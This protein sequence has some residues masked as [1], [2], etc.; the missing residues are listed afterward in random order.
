[1]QFLSGS[2]ILIL[3]I[4]CFQK[5]YDYLYD[6]HLEWTEYFGVGMVNKNK[7]SYG[8]L[9]RIGFLTGMAVM[10]VM[11]AA[12]LAGRTMPEKKD[13]GESFILTDDAWTLDTSGSIPADMKHLGDGF[14]SDSDVLSIYYRLPRMDVAQSLVWRTKDV[15]TRLAVDGEVLYETEVPQSRF[16]SKSPGNIWN[17]CDIMPEYSG[18]V[19]EMQ[20]KYAYDESTVTVDHIYM[21]NEA[22]IVTGLISGKTGALLI[23]IFM[24]LAGLFMLFINFIPRLNTKKGNGIFYLGLNTLFSGIWSLLETNVVQFFVSDARLLQMVGNVVMM[25]SVLPLLL[26]LDCEYHIL[27]N[28]FLQLLSC[29]DIVFLIVCGIGQ[30]TGVTDL[31][32]M[33][34]ISLPFV[35]IFHMVLMVTV[36]KRFIQTIRSREKNLMVSLQMLGVV[37][38]WVIT[39]F[40]V[41]RFSHT[42]SMDR[43]VAIRPG[44]L[45]FVLLFAVS[46]E[47]S[48]F[49]L[50]QNGMQYDL[51]RNL[52][53][54]DGLTNLGNRTSYLEQLNKYD[55]IHIKRLGM[56]F[57]D[58]NN[59]KTVNDNLGHEEGDKLLKLAAEVIASTFGKYGNSYRIGGDEFCVFLEAEKPEEIYRKAKEEFYEAVGQV[60]SARYY[61]FELQIAH[62]FAQCENANKLRLKE[63][64]DQAD[65]LMY[66]NKEQLKRSVKTA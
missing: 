39:I 2:F 43:A 61:P 25:V 32:D 26:Y 38:L 33:L 42:D 21:G 45:V 62:G 64:V 35:G 48:A 40:E 63:M 37:S 18:K 41:A 36:V 60:N 17:T 50:M 15:Y 1:M 23:S 27:K 52:A 58:V 65:T 47:I 49:R 20:V 31:H 8:K 6:R 3:S 66:I 22:D 53:Y 11:I 34:R 7:D 5:E 30:L 9:I 55:E 16:Y 59:L 28:R 54:H 12:V 13:G 24:I 57:L 46:S 56:V 19:L 4:L 44:M 51:I 29:L 14:S 10:F